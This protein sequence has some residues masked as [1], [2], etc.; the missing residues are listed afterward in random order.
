MR[1][2]VYDPAERLCFQSELYALFYSGIFERCLVLRDGMLRCFPRFFQETS[3][4]QYQTQT[5]FIDPDFPKDWLCFTNGDLAD[6]PNFPR[7]LPEDNW[8]AFRGY[9]WVWEDRKTVKALLSGASVPLVQTQ[10]ADKAV[11]SVL[12]GWNYVTTQ[13]EADSLLEQAEDFHDSVLV[14]LRY[15]SG[16]GKTDR[17]IRIPDHIRQVT[18]LFHS[19]W[20][21]PLELVFEAVKALDLRPAGNNVRSALMEAT[22]RVRDA[23]V[24][25][26]DGDDEGNEAA[27]P[28]TKILAYSLRWR[29]LPE[30]S[31]T[32]SK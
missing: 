5:S 27:Y 16:S 6:F 19:D 20:C 23:A 30:E 12:P 4:G 24:F 10:F 15:I 17:G 28:G 31:S 3:S 22:L 11:S 7:R 8:E 26:C 14:E 13:A 9:P 25:F 1:V 32:T 21:P 29:F 2:R 18:M